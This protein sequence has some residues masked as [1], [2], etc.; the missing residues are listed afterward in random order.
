MREFYGGWGFNRST[1]VYMYSDKRGYHAR[2]RVYHEDAFDKQWHEKTFFGSTPEVVGEKV[3]EYLE[4][5]VDKPILVKTYRG[6]HEFPGNVYTEDMLVRSV[7][8]EFHIGH[9]TRPHKDDDFVP[10]SEN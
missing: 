9:A 6:S 10:V 7:V 2:A 4:S 5:T 8:N 1:S 3:V